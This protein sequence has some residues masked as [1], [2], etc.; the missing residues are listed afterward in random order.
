MKLICTQENFNRGLE[1]VSRVASKNVT[2]PILNNVLLKAEKGTLKLITTNLELGI[3]CLVR[4]KVEKEGSFTVRA[5]I[6]NDLVSL[7][8]NEKINLEVVGD[9]LELQAANNRTKIKGLSAEEFPL[10]PEIPKKNG[11]SCQAKDFRLALAEIIFAVAVDESRPEI[12]GVF[13]GFKDNKLT[14]ASTDSYRLAE[15]TIKLEKGQGG[16]K[17]IIVP[18][19]TLQELLR[20]LTEETSEIEIYFTENQILFC[21]DEVNLVSRLIEGQYPDYQQIIPKDSKTK[22]IIRTE[23]FIKL[24]KGTSLFCKPGINDLSLSFEPSSGKIILSAV[25]NQ[26]GE[27]VSEADAK[28]TGEPN[29]IVFNYR[30]LLDGLINMKAAEVSLEIVN[31]N[32]PGLLKPV[33]EETYLYIIMPIKQ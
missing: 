10:I 5:R 9:S 22:A 23:E 19:R 8:G 15:K 16:E 24:I 27:N 17:S 4:S 25:N 14:L 26:L 32:N 7:L 18:V 31:D 11:Y 33:G 3:T 1:I 29:K 28:L 2:L 6:I 21:W 30:Y 20:I 12:S 13:M